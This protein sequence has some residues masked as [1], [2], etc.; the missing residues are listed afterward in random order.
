MGI[1]RSALIVRPSATVPSYERDWFREPGVQNASAANSAI[2]LRPLSAV[3]NRIS[4]RADVIR[5]RVRTLAGH[6]DAY[7][8]DIAGASWEDRNA[9]R[10]C[11]NAVILML[12]AL[13]GLGVRDFGEPHAHALSRRPFGSIYVAKGDI[14]RLQKGSGADQL[15]RLH[16][17][18]D[19]QDADH[20]L[21]V[22]C[23]YVQ[24]HFS[25]HVGEGARQKVG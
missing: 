22:I 17:F 19:A 11:E 14:R 16:R 6:R 2:K 15:H 13:A 8:Q 23:Q 24:A 7:G 21:Q 1:S 18:R 10:P 9:A 12:D 4:P 20:P 25:A 3:Y 5:S